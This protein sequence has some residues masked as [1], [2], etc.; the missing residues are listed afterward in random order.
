MIYISDAVIFVNIV[1]FSVFAN[2]IARGSFFF[3]FFFYCMILDFIK[4]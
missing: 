1:C 4:I 3:F 2:V